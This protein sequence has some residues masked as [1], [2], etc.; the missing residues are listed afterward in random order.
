MA[1]GRLWV[2]LG[3]LLGT[4]WALLGASWALLGA[5]WPGFFEALIPDRIQIPSKSPFAS[6]W[7][8]WGRGFGRVLMEFGQGFWIYAIYAIYTVYAVYAI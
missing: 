6:I 1:L 3:R 8:R 7:G 4:S 5:P 2:A